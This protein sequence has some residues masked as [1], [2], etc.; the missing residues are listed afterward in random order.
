MSGA[1]TRT[2]TSADFFLETSGFAAARMFD[3]AGGGEGKLKLGAVNIDWKGR[4]KTFV[5]TSGLLCA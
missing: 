3:L 2:R 4:G 5:T 1:A